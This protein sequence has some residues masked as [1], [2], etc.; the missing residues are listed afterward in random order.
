MPFRPG[1]FFAIFGLFLPK[2]AKNR[3]LAYIAG[4][5]A[6]IAKAERSSKKLELGRAAGKTPAVGDIPLQGS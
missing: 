6:Y 1:P 5:P 2:I 4:A 3:A